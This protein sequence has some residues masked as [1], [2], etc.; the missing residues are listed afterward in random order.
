MLGVFGYVVA[1]YPTVD[2]FFQLLDAQ[3]TGYVVVDV[4]VLGWLASKLDL[5]VQGR[6]NSSISVTLGISL[7]T[8]ER[9]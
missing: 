8:V 7:Q 4:R 2:S 6:T 9:C 5:V 3:R 1:T